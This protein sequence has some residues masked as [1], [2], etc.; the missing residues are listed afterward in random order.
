MVYATISRENDIT[1]VDTATGLTERGADSPGSIKVP[2]SSAITEIRIGVAADWTAD[3]LLGFSTGLHIYGSGC[4]EQWV[5]GP[6]GATG[7]AAATSSG[8]N[9]AEP[10]VYPCNIPVIP[11]NE[12]SLAGFMQGEDCGSLRMMVTLVFDGPV[13]GKVK[14]FDYREVDLASANTPVTLS[15]RGGVTENDFKVGNETI[16]EV[17][18]GAGCKVVA[19]PL[20]ATTL[21]IIT[22]AGTKG[23]LEFQGNSIT[24]QDDPTISG[25]TNVVSLVKYHTLIKTETGDLR[26]QGQE[27]EDDVGTPFSVCMLGFA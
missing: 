13:K 1:A 25:A 2:H 14:R 27:V 8:L 15:V 9:I 11:G 26:V 7:G 21:F 16:V 3:T 17:H 20:A 22:G 12:I 19:G 4:A 24:V 23:N 6:V 18:V 5:A 10:A